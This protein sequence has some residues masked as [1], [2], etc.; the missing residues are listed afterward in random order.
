MLLRSTIQTGSGRHAYLRTHYK[1]G[2]ILDIGNLGGERLVGGSFF[3]GY[4]EFVKYAT[5]SVVFGFDKYPPRDSAQ[6]PNQKVGDIEDGLPYSDEFFD[7]VYMGELIE[8]LGNPLHALSEIYR[9]LKPGGVLILDTPNAYSLRRI[10]R[11][12]LKGEDA[13]GGDPTH[14]IFFTPASIKRVIEEA[15]FVVDNMS[16]KG[17]SIRGFN[18][19]LLVSAHK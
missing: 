13:L 14:L 5:E 3:S 19:T 9:V 4:L 8:H 6:Y 2:Q 11:F 15:G 17:N 18:S 12:L 16:E 1:K 7:T 10:F